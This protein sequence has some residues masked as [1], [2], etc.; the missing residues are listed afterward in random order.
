M[1][2]LAIVFGIVAGVVQLAGYWVYNKKLE[3]KEINP[4]A[5]TWAIWGL[6]SF[7]AVMLYQDLAHD[8]VKEFL[9]IV[10]S[11]AA[12]GTFVHMMIKGSFQRPDRLDIEMFLLDTAVVTYWIM[13]DDP[14]SANVLLEVD[15][16]ISFLPILRS[17]WNKPE[18]EDPKPW[19]IWSI[20]YT[21]LTV[22]VLMRW[23]KWWDLLLPVNYLILHLAIWGIAKFRTARS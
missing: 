22:T 18:T 8:W 11:I 23:E 14:I 7:V 13:S 9:P 20:A 4:N 16:W 17:T 5:T 15:I 19:F 12:F 10:C 21:L 1:N 3:S 2:T 6:G